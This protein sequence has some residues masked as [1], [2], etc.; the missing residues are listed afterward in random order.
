MVLWLSIEKYDRALV[1]SWR[2]NMDGMLLFAG[3]FSASLTAFIIESYQTLS[4]DTGAATV[5]L[6]AQIS[7]Q[8][9]A[10]ANGSALV[11]SQPAPFDPPATAVVCNALWFISLGLSLRC[12]LVATLL[13]QWARDYLHKANLR[14]APF[15][16]ARIFSYLYYGL[17]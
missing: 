15:I 3:L 12:A 2:S 10:S 13:E 6:L 4:P 1:E 9:V 7:Q 11:V 14:S 5:I 17:K 8:L 16:R